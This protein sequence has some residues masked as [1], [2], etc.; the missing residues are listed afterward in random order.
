MAGTA[1]PVTSPAPG[2]SLFGVAASTFRFADILDGVNG[3]LTDTGY[4]VLLG[5]G[6]IGRQP[7][8][9]TVRIS[10]PTT[11]SVTASS[12]TRVISSSRRRAIALL[13]GTVLP[14]VIGSER[15][16]N[17]VITLQ[18]LTRNSA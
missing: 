7:C 3:Q 2:A 16:A 6:P 18:D 13:A 11:S 5:R 4:Q 12:P 9:T 1:D 10:T 17:F 15:E 8:E 14:E